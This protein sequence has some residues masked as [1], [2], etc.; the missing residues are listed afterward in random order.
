MYSDWAKDEIRI[1]GLE[2]YAHHGVYPEE[3]RKGQVFY[4]N[5]VLYTDTGKAGTRDNLEYTA[6]YGAVCHFITNWMQENTCLLLEAAAEKLARE[7][8][9]KYPAVSALDMEIQKP[10]A[11]IKL[12]FGNVSVKIHRSWHKAYIAVGSNMGDRE[13]YLA[14]AVESM[15]AHPLIEVRQVSDWI[16]TKAYGGVEQEDFLNGAIEVETLLNPRELLEALHVME[17]EAGRKRTV[18]WGPR[19]LD[20]DILFYDKLVMESQELV[21]P[22]IDLENRSF[23]LK[24]LAQIAPYLR[25]PVTG[26]TVEALLGLLTDPA[27][28]MPGR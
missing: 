6:D 13:G 15:R 17:N 21:I 10:D 11:P 12:P 8:L 14:G 4:V 19:T 20:L 23:V 16:V 2:V 26:R 7:I 5:A 27:P 1:E 25:H 24:P 22:H 28:G 18:R 3:T 9:L